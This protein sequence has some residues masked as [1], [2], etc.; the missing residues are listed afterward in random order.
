MTLAENSPALQ[1]QVLI[2]DTSGLCHPLTKM[3][4]PSMSPFQASTRALSSFSASATYTD[5]ILPEGWS[6]FTSDGS[7]S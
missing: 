2:G 5:H 6:S 7:K 4:R 1:T 3:R